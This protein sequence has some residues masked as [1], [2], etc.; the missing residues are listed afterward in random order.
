[1]GDTEPLGV[2]LEEAARYLACSTR[3]V[4]RLLKRGDLEGYY[5]GSGVRVTWRSLMALTQPRPF[6]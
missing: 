5:V 2:S 1:M 4:R 3:T 6:A